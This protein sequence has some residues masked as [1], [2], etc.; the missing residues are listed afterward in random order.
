MSALSGVSIR[1]NET[2]IILDEI[3]EI[4]RGLTSLK[5]FCENAREYHV[6][7]AG[8][9][10]GIALHKD[11]SFPAGKVD[12]LE[13]YPMNFEE[14]LT[15]LGKDEFVRILHDKDWQSMK[16]LR[17]QHIE[18]LRQYYFVGGMPEAVLTYLTRKDIL[19]V[20]SV[21]NNILTAYQNDVSKHAPKREIPRINMVWRSIPSQLAR[22]NKKFVFGAL[23]K[24]ARVNDFEIAIQWLLDCGV[25]YK[26]NRIN[27]ASIP[28]S[29]YE[30]LSAFKLFMLDCGLMGALSATPPD[31]ILIGDNIFR[32]YKGAFAENFV[33]Q[34]MKT[35]NETYIYYY[36]NSNSTMK[37]DFVVQH[38]SKVI[39]IEVIAEENLRAKSLH[40]YITD[41]P[42]LHGIRLS[43]SDYRE[44]I[45]MTNIPLF[46]VLESL[47]N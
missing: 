41:N 12:I 29:F 28:L 13:M 40:Q 8:S 16:T 14:F 36:S 31:Q 27:A 6:A 7:V 19:E 25:V 30:D 39:P 5:Y 43:M 38:Y 46:A 23:K 32:E 17:S 34:Q 21:Q 2:L 24:G 47:D 10:L 26:V 37:I 22:E 15:A 45:W 42:N 33:L 9:L 44:Q 20:R 3:Q 1:P 11:T 18:L 35:I 4:P